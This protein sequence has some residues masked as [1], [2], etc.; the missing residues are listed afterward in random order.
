MQGPEEVGII[1]GK[2]QA[3]PADQSVAARVVD[4]G[5]MLAGI[6]GIARTRVMTT[7]YTEVTAS[8][9]ARLSQGVERK[10]AVFEPRYGLAVQIAELRE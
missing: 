10:G 9:R 1:E 3:F 2:D 7:G 4:G 5:D 6:W 8:R